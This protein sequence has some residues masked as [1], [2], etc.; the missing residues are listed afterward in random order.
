LEDLQIMARRRHRLAERRKAIGLSQERLAEAM[1][2]DRGTVARWELAES[3]PQPWSR[4]SLAR[5]L[6][7]SVDELAELLADVAETP[8]PTTLT[9]AVLPGDG[10]VNAGSILTIVFRLGSRA[11]SSGRRNGDDS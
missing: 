11:D 4:P 2:I 3:A 5:I 8:R 6:K 10:I 7:V 1:G 9:V